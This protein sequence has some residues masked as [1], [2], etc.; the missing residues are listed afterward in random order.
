MESFFKHCDQTIFSAKHLEINNP[1]H[2]KCLSIFKCPFFSALQVR[3]RESNF[4]SS[5]I[6]GAQNFD[7]SLNH[8]TGKTK[9]SDGEKGVNKLEKLEEKSGKSPHPKSQQT[10]NDNKMPVEQLTSH[11]LSSVAN[12]SAVNLKA[13]SGIQNVVFNIS[14]FLLVHHFIILLNSSCLLVPY[15]S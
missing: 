13:I 12:P 2:F 9:V 15:G 5:L 10:E 14:L 11:V 7:L 4:H 6:Q 3:I 8:Q 1:K